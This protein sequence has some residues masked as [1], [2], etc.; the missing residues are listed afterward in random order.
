VKETLQ[1]YKELQD[2]IAILGLDEL[3][4]EDRLTVARAENRT[5][6]LATILRRGGVYR[7]SW[8]V[9]EFGGDD[10]GF[11]HSVRQN[12]MIFPSNL[13][14]WL[15]TWESHLEGGFTAV[16]LTPHHITSLW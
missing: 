4:E 16:T 9:C 13:S 7:L 1:R 2:I 10:S 11:Q 12:W 6:S 14:I 8:K 15:E 5:F 3:S